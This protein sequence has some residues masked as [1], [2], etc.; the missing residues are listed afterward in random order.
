M[1]QQE[2]RAVCGRSSS[3][4]REETG[5]AF[6]HPR[7]ERSFSNPAR[8]EGDPLLLLV[9]AGSEKLS[10]MERRRAQPFFVD[11]MGAGAMRD[12]RLSVLLQKS[13]LPEV[14]R[15]RKEEERA[16]RGSVV[17]QAA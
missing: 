14:G 7:L 2:K 1:D 13:K 10:G 16:G 8:Q 9:A 3:Y 4:V 17:E 15:L 5:A 6:W 12:C 11:Q